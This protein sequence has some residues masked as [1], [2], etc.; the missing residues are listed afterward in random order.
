MAH[1]DW[2]II[3]P[4]ARPERVA[5]TV[6][7][8]VMQSLAAGNCEILVVTPHANAVH[9]D[10]KTV[11]QLRV[12]QT[13]I[14]HSPGRMR[15]IGV[16]ESRGAYLFFLD[17]DCFAPSRILEDMAHVLRSNDRVGAVGCRVVAWEQTF[18][19]QCADH[20]L[21]TAYQA[22]TAGSV[23]GLGSAALA[24]RREAFLAA[25]GFDEE[26]MA[27]EDWDF[28]LKLRKQGW[29]CWFAPEIEVRHDHRRGSFRAIL[30]AAWNYG[31]ASGLIVQQ[32]HEATVSWVARLLVAAARKKLYW[33]VMLPYSGFLTLVWVFETRPL[34]MLPC[35]PVLFLARFSYQ[36]G[37]L[38]A[39]QGA[40]K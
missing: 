23:E 1:V 37:V 22:K 9:I 36:C 33:L 21:F 2:S 7:S 10:A 6:R 11:V 34:K 28:S 29:L 24:V 26:L 25:G 20:A 15:N 39:L 14:L 38:K 31:K 12:I 8:L 40:K 35:M 16:Q 32:R 30:G 19:N 27:S 5:G 17:D 13:G 18:W 3:I 4:S